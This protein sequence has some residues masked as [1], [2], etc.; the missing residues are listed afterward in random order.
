MIVNHY[1]D[2]NVNNHL[3]FTSVYSTFLVISQVVPWG[4]IIRWCTQPSCHQAR[5]FHMTLTWCVLNL[6]VLFKVGCS[7]VGIDIDIQPS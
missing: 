5:L 4:V 6:L 2:N 1:H 7:T 3:L